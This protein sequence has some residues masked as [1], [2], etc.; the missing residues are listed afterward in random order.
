MDIEQLLRAEMRVQDPGPAFTASLMARIRG[1]AGSQFRNRLTII[2]I[3]ATFAVAAMM[4]GLQKADVRT[5]DM[6]RGLPE[7]A[8]GTNGGPAPAPPGDEA[9]SPMASPAAA[10]PEAGISTQPPVAAEN[11]APQPASRPGFTVLVT[12]RQDHPDPASRAP[13]EAF[14]AALLGELRKVPGLRL[15]APDSPEAEAPLVRL[16]VVS[17]APTP[18]PNG[19]VRYQLTQSQGSV[20]SSPRAPGFET[21]WPLEF[22]VQVKGQGSAGITMGVGIDGFL[23]LGRQDV[24]RPAFCDREVVSQ[25]TESQC[26]STSELA[27]RQVSYLRLRIFPPDPALRGEMLSRVGDRAATERARFSGLY[28]VVSAFRKGRGFPPDGEALRAILSLAADAPS[29]R[30]QV[31]SQIRGYRHPGLIDP[32]IASLRTDPDDLVRKEALTTLLAD[33]AGNERVLD[34]L[35]AVADEGSSELIRMLARR[36]VSGEGAWREYVIS[37]LRNG[38]LSLEQRA[39]ALRHDSD[40]ASTE[41]QIAAVVALVNDND[42]IDAVLLAARDGLA[43]TDIMQRAAGRHALNALFHHRDP[44]SGNPRW[45]EAESLYNEYVGPNSPTRIVAPP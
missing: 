43:E 5:E 38:S 18:L 13:V 30:A 19:G 9:G 34:A 35:G 45:R 3:L 29:F 40:H 10:E 6:V 36:A 11:V 32:L 31:W 8:T 17:L 21:S 2:G 15:V 25:S 14:H 39:A 26:M 44:A 42:V 28:E 23:H 37:T 33:Y 22:D 20:T 4:I 7:Q 41:G 1:R 12:L 27:A 24:P 16:S